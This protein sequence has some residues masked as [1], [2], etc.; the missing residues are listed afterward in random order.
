MRSVATVQLDADDIAL[1]SYVYLI[2]MVIVFKRNNLVG[3]VYPKDQD[4]MPQV[5]ALQP[6]HAVVKIFISVIWIC[7]DPIN[8]FENNL[9]LFSVFLLEPA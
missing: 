3:M 1:S 4:E 7:E 6:F 9:I 2:V 5:D 8:L